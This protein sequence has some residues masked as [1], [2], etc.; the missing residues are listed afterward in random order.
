MKGR[1]N[2]KIT[3]GTT[4]ARTYSVSKASFISYFSFS[5]KSTFQFAEPDSHTLSVSTQLTFNKVTLHWQPQG[6]Q[7]AGI[8]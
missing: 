5:T 4:V 6:V 8:K 3:L 1:K 7:A 2:A